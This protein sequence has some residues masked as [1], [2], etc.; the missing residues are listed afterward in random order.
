MPQE[1]NSVPEDENLV[2]AIKQDDTEAFKLL[3]DKYFA[4]LIRFAL[5]RTNSMDLSRELVQEIF[6]RMWIKRELL[7]PE[8]SVKSYLYKSLNNL[9]I[10]RSK[11]H[12]TKNISIEDISRKKNY[13]ADMDIDFLIDM[14]ENINRLPEKIKTV[15]LLSRVEGYKYNEIADICGI[16]TKAVEKRMSR[17]FLILKKNLS[18]NYFK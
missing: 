1:N 13:K 14:Q 17:A 6:F 3:Y 9:I 7:N 16:S 12:S 15:F 8:K 4:P 2:R 5:Y 10:N 18:E 11:L